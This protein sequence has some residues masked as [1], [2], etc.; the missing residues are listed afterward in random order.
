M[1][2]A[3]D[4]VIGAMSASDLPDVRRVCNA[5]FG[6]GG[7]VAVDEANPPDIFGERLFAYRFGAD[8]EGCLVARDGDGRVAAIL[9]SVARGSLG[10]FG[11]LA[12]LPSA[13]KTGVGA[14]LVEACHESW[15]RRGVRLRGLET[16]PNSTY[17]VAFYGRLG[18]RP[19]WTGVGFERAIGATAVPAGVE[20][21]GD[22]PDLS[23]LY[24]DL[25]VRGEA[26]AT[27][28][29]GA[30]SVVTT[31]DGVA[32]VHV[33]STFQRPDTVM[34]PFAAAASRAGFDRLIGAAEHLGA[35]A[36]KAAVFV[37]AP[38]GA[39]GTFDALTERGYHAGQV[40]VRMKRG[41]RPDYDRGD[42]YYVDN[43]L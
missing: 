37:R 38:G 18:Y 22:L 3:Q 43:W 33:E 39:T 28:S 15:D 26:A 31:D 20:T 6:A 14:A 30:G 19:G 35:A 17:H 42:V 24:P 5:A 8:P 10:W 13:Q 34:V 2:R 23:F 27:L 11:P 7:G 21:G 9:I 16:L 12:T 29:A 25:D 41:E 1:S 32:L 4:F 40:F 36:G